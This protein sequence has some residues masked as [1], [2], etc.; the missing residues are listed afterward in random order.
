MPMTTGSPLVQR[1]HDLL[2]LLPSR[3]SR[4]WIPSQAADS[5]IASRVTLR[6]LGRRVRTGIKADEGITAFTGT[7]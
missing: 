1:E 4:K 3:A 5:G 2:Q 6:R 7:P